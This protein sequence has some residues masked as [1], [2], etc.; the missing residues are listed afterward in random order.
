MISEKIFQPT[1]LFSI[2][3]MAVIVMMVLPMPSIILDIGLAVSFAIAILM[4]SI[5]LFIV[6]P[7]DFSSFPTVLL[8][9]LLLR[10]S[11]NV[12]ST[13][14][15]IGHGHEGVDAAGKVIEG[16]ASFIMGGSTILGVVTF[17]VLLI[18][19]FVVINK[20]ATRMAEVGAR[21]ALD[22]MPGKQLSIDSDLSSGSINHSEAKRLRE[23]EQAETTFFGS[24]DGASKFVK[25]DA[26]AGLMITALNIIVGMIMGVGIHGMPFKEAFDTYTIL[27]VGDGLVSQI[28]SVIISVASALLLARGGSTGSIDASLIKQMLGYP[29][30]VGTVAIVMAFFAIM[31]G[32][33]FLPFISA[34]IGL[35]Y[36]AFRVSLPSSTTDDA[37]EVQPDPRQRHRPIGD[38][39]D[40]DEIHI[41]FA[42]DLVETVLDFRTG[43]DMRI[44]SMREHIASHF[45]LILP[46]MRLTDNAAL[47]MGTYVIRILGVEHARGVLQV[48]QVLAL[49]PS[50]GELE[51]PGVDVAEPVYGAPA[52][53]IS[54]R[55]QNDAATD[56]IT[57]V[58][59]SEVLSTHLLETLKR[60]LARFMTMKSLRRVL[61]ELV[62]LT[63]AS[64]S[65]A[66]RRFLDEMLPD[67]VPMDQLLAVLRLLLEERVSIRNLHLIIESIAEVRGGGTS[68][69][70]IVEYVRQRL[71]YQILSELKRSNGSVPVVQLAPEWED[72]FQRYQLSSDKNSEIALPAELF[73]KLSNSL[74]D[75][76]SKANEGGDRIAVISTSKRRRFLRGVMAAKGLSAAVISFEEVGIDG[77]LSLVGTVTT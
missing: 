29:A 68:I 42:P 57:T 76:L 25:G 59:P 32:M 51:I 9:S 67:R 6:R 24:L 14:L 71:G 50:S 49:R 37:A 65:D 48:G 27:T 38:S 2:A 63:D 44:V 70:I 12:S 43:L 30:A 21:F 64:R 18:V 19:N 45:G 31:P 1:V 8:A 40:L 39:L 22:A 53:W 74:A 36:L 20:G 15:I 60:N 34:A 41:E 77:K 3:L 73:N 17:F 33:P 7:L 5:T 58:A 72:I 10:L 47:P 16:F 11:L 66:N 55:Y 54:A 35:G 23:I 69:E 4:F 26:I 56:G 28:P 13:K 46:E 61:D 62:H 75:K 52:R